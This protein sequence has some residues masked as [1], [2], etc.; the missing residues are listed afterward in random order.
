MVQR[1]GQGPIDCCSCRYHERSRRCRRLI[2]AT[3]AVSHEP[4]A[5]VRLETSRAKEGATLGQTRGGWWWLL[6]LVKRLVLVVVV[7]RTVCFTR[8]SGQSRARIQLIKM[9]Q[10]QCTS[11]F[12]WTVQPAKTP[13]LVPSEGRCQAS[14][15]AKKSSPNSKSRKKIARHAGLT[16][17]LLRRKGGAIFSI[18]SALGAPDPECYEK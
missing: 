3:V 12:G 5:W 17:P 9:G 15:S 4:P 14:P 7:V 13:T 2:A 11:P 1:R 18:S 16:S 6:W 8:V 10:C